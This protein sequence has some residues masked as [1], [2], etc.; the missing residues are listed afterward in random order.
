MPKLI[1]GFTGKLAS[2]KAVCQNYLNDKYNSDSFRFSTALRDVLDRLYI[3]ISRTNLQDLSLALRHTFGSNILAEVISE[4]A[5]NSQK[6]I[7]VID[8]IR[9]LDDISKLKNLPGFK[10]I[11][12]DA[13]PQL[14]YERMK[15]RNENKGDSEKSYAQFE[16][17][18]QREAELQ[19]PEVM[20]QADF[21]LDNN[22]DLKQLYQGIDRII[23]GLNKD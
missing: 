22:G 19:I 1:L 13:N 3:P 14:R 11:S 21:H 7:V 17:D 6:D 4:D 23:E 10:L 2:G 8:G 18:G 9:R 5:K 20:A 16:E 15:K 12:I